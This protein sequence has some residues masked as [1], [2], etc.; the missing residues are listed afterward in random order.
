MEIGIDVALAIIFEIFSAFSPMLGGWLSRLNNFKHLSDVHYTTDS[1][2]LV[3]CAVE[4]VAYLATLALIFV[5]AWEGHNLSTERGKASE[6]FDTNDWLGT[7]ALTLLLSQYMSLLI[8]LC[9]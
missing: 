6:C 4:R 3:L 2:S 5:P 7:G 9:F 8:S 1:I